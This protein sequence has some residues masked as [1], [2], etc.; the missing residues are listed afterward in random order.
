MEK[1]MKKITCLL[2]VLFILFFVN[3]AIAGNVC[4]WEPKSQNNISEDACMTLCN[5]NN[6]QNCYF[7]G[8]F[9]GLPTECE[10]DQRFCIQTTVIKA[11]TVLETGKY[12][13]SP[14]GKYTLVAQKDGNLVLYNNGNGA[15][16]A[17]NTRT[18]APNLTVFQNDGNFVVYQGIVDVDKALWSSKTHGNPNST[19]H[20]ANDGRLYILNG[21]G[22]IIRIYS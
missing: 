3:A 5:N 2:S 1:A 16:W 22:V 11:G 10:Y 13:S 12:Y 9:N 14:N 21:N 19:L 15:K 20:I 17:A 7:I 6:Y 18:K 8:M 4:Y